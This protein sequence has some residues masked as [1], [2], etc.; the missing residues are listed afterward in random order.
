MAGTLT[1]STLSDGT[2]NSPV[3]DVVRG[4]AR[5]WVNFNGT[6]TVAIRA[7][8]NISSITDSGVGTYGL[9]FTTPL[10]DTNYTVIGSASRGPGTDAHCMFSFPAGFTQTVSTVQV[11]GQF[12][13]NYD[14]TLDPTFMFVAVFR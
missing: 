12:I 7:S 13:T 8:Y 4:S 10:A 1:I 2:N 9:N 3:T 5:V 6:G 11:R 14:A